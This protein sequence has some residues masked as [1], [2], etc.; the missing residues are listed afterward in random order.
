M[1][2]INIKIIVEK[3]LLALLHKSVFEPSD[4][5]FGNSC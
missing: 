5:N 4:L 3:V 2:H 1:A